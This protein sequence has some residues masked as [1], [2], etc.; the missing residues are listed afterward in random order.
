M[1]VLSMTNF[2]FTLVR[3]AGDIIKIANLKNMKKYRIIISLHHSL[4]DF[5]F[6][7]CM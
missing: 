1:D 7:L 2:S 5:K 6:P 3:H 4:C